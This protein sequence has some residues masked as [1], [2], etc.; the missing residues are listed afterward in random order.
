ME[1]VTTVHPV[2]NMSNV[3]HAVQRHSG[4]QALISGKVYSAI[5]S[6]TAMYSK[7]HEHFCRSHTAA[8]CGLHGDGQLN[9][10][11][12]PLFLKAPAVLYRCVV[13]A[14][15]PRHLA[16]P[17]KLNTSPHRQSAD[18]GNTVLLLN[19]RKEIVA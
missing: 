12:Q 1:T 4:P 6:S 8:A 9:S 17:E 3:I 19:H 13:K 16:H 5:I 7:N 11:R 15:A 18:N 2:D 14:I 10:R